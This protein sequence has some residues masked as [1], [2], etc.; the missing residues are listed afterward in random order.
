M[1]N[2]RRTVTLL[3]TCFSLVL[4]PSV[5][6][7]ASPDQA[8]SPSSSINVQ[9]D[10]DQNGAAKPSRSFLFALSGEGASLRPVSG[11]PGTYRLVA[12]VK[13]LDER[14]NWFTDR[15]ARDAG[16]LPLKQFINLWSQDGVN[17]FK[18]DPPNIALAHNNR[19]LIAVMSQPEVVN[20]SSGKVFR[21]TLTTLPTVQR[22]A[23]SQGEGNLSTHAKRG[24]IAPG[25]TSQKMGDFS[26]FVDNEAGCSG[27]CCCYCIGG[28]NC[29]EDCYPGVDGLTIC[30]VICGTNC[31]DYCAWFG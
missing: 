15:P 28:S 2:L 21:T 14:V 7:I 10:K 27:D 5:T 29:G 3:T 6:A 23:L 12:P 4:L 30:G 19:T 13:S 24:A 18:N 1:R 22:T 26:V 17:S 25:K 9:S 8:S 31:N 20:S 11:K 16:T